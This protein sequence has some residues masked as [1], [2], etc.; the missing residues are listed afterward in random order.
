MTYQCYGL[1]VYVCIQQFK[2]NEKP[3]R[4]PLKRKPSVHVY[5]HQTW[6]VRVK[7]GKRSRKVRS[8]NNLSSVYTIPSADRVRK[9]LRNVS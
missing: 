6:S 2:K 4:L 8:L 9:G 3:P 5:S 7:Y 1:T